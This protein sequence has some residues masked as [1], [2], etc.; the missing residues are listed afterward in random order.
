MLTWFE[1]SSFCFFRWKIDQVE[2][3]IIRRG[4]KEHTCIL[5]KGRMTSVGAR[6][7]NPNFKQTLW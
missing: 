5:I 7:T 6:R 2:E 1:Y 3:G 4:R